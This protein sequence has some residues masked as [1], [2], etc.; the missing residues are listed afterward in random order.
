MVLI[1]FHVLKN[2]FGLFIYLPFIFSAKLCGGGF[3]S[4][5]FMFSLHATYS[6]IFWCFPIRPYAMNFVAKPW[7]ATQ[8]LKK[9]KLKEFPH[10]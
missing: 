1:F 7:Y 6:Q 9:I 10:A 3:I 2:T 4:S 8:A 5:Y